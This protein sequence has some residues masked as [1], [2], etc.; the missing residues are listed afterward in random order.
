M[1]IEHAN[2]IAMSEI[3]GKL[4][5]QPKRTNNNK[6]WYLSPLRQEK[7]A[8]FQVDTKTNRW[9]DF[10]EGIGGDLVD[11]VCAYLK[12][13]N[14]ANTVSD[15]LRWIKNMGV[16]PFKIGTVYANTNDIIKPDSSLILKMKKPIQHIGLIHYLAKRGIPLDTAHQHL[17]RSAFT[18]RER[19][20]ISRPLAFAM[21]RAGL[22]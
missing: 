7:T 10:G 8:S 4:N 5:R 1:N 13:T 20:K 14:E 11:F 21:R 9:H 18:I 2:T 17:K 12:S 16:A 15:A 3:L 22:N 6:A 19:R